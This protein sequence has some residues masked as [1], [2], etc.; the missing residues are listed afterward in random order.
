METFLLLNGYEISASVDD[1]EQ[2]I[3]GIASGKVLRDELLIWIRNHLAPRSMP[4][5]K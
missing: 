1:A 3:L 4:G 5:T 2:I